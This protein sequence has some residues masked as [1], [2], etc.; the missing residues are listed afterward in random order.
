MGYNGTTGLPTIDYRIVDSITDPPGSDDLE[1][2][3]LIRLD[4]CFLCYTP[5][6]H[7]PP[8]SLRPDD[9]PIV[10]GSFNTMLKIGPPVAAL[11]ARVLR[12]VPGSRLIIKNPTLGNADTASACR[13]LFAR[14][15]VVHPALQLRGPTPGRAEHMAMYADIDIALDPFPYNG[16]TTTLESLWMG[17][18]V[19]NLVGDRHCARAGRSLLTHAGLSELSADTPDD[20]IRIA[21]QLAADHARRRGLRTSLR[22]S[23]RTALCDAPSFTRRIEAAYRQMWRD[24]CRSRRG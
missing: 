20:Y 3:R 13:Q 6:H 14:E 24:W 21:A 23:V 15:G 10:F 16:T 2:E 9:Q 12:A 22:E 8:I 4:G 17:V 1:T 18:P 7:A 11:W 19:V 5:P